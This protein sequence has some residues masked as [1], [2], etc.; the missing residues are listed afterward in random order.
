[1]QLEITG[2]KLQF[3]LDV[4]CNKMQVRLNESCKMEYLYKHKMGKG[5]ETLIFGLKESRL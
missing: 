4:I 5:I 2:S 3:F 1:M